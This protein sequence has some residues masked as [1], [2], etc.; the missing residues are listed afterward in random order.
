[1]KRYLRRLTAGCLAVLM[2][3][4]NGFAVNTEGNEA[5]ANPL[6]GGLLA[7]PVPLLPDDV[8]L[9]GLQSADD[10]VDYSEPYYQEQLEQRFK[11]EEAL[12]ELQELLDRINNGEE[13]GC[14]ISL[15]APAEEKPEEEPPAED[16]PVDEKPVEEPSEENKPDATPSE[17]TD[18]DETE[19]PT[20][21]TTDDVY[22][23]EPDAAAE[24][25]PMM[26]AL[27]RAA[28]PAQDATT[29][30]YV[31]ANGVPITIEDNGSGTKVTWDGGGTGKEITVS[32][33]TFVFGGSKDGNVTSTDITFKSGKVGYIVG[34]GLNG[35]VTGDT[36]VTINNNTI[37]DSVKGVYGGGVF[38]A[39]DGTANVTVAGINATTASIYGGGMNSG[40]TVGSTSVTISGG[41]LGTVYAG[42][43]KGTVTGNTALLINGGTISWAYG[44][45]SNGSVDGAATV[46]FVGGTV[47]NNL[48][49]GGNKGTVSSTKVTV[50]GGTVSGPSETNLGGVVA[51]GAQASVTNSELTIRSDLKFACGGGHKTGAASTNMKVN[52]ERGEVTTLVGG[53]HTGVENNEKIEVNVS[54]ASLGKIG[55][56]NQLVCAD[57]A[58][59]GSAT[60]TFNMTGGRVDELR[61]GF[62]GSSG[63][64]T[65]KVTGGNIMK[66]GIGVPLKDGSG[67]T[68]YPVSMAKVESGSLVRDLSGTGDKDKDILVTIN[69]STWYSKLNTSGQLELQ[70]PE[71]SFNAEAI[72]VVVSGSSEYKSKESS[73]LPNK[74]NSIE[75][76]DKGGPYFIVNFGAEDDNTGSVSCDGK[77]QYKDELVSS[78]SLTFN[79]NPASGYKLVGWWKNGVKDT[80]AT[81]NTLTLNITESVEI[82]ARFVVASSITFGSLPRGIRNVS[83]TYAGLGTPVE[84]NTDTGTL[85]GVQKDTAVTFSTASGSDNYEFVSWKVNDERVG[86]NET[87]FKWTADGTSAKVEA[88]YV[89]KI[90]LRNLIAKAKPIY[91]DTSEAANKNYYTSS[92][93]QDADFRKAY[94]AA[95]AA[96]GKTEL[97]GANAIPTQTEID[98][99]KT[100]LESTMN[101]VQ[102]R[103]AIPSLTG[104]TI[105]VSKGGTVVSNPAY[106]T[107]GGAVT[108]TVTPDPGYELKEADGKKL[109][110]TYTERSYDKATGE[111]KSETKEITPTK[112]ETN[113]PYTYTFNMPDWGAVVN[114][115]AEFTTP[116][117]DV[118]Y[119]LATGNDG[120]GTIVVASKPDSI[121]DSTPTGGTLSNVTVNDTIKFKATAE[122][123]K[124]DGKSYSVGEWTVTPADGAVI[125]S[126]ETKDTKGTTESICTLTKVTK[127][128]TVTV[129]FT[130][131]KHRITFASGANGVAS[132]DAAAGGVEKD[133]SDNNFFV[134]LAGE[135]VTIKATPTTG[136]VPEATFTK[137]DGSQSQ[138]K[139]V[140]VNEP[141]ENSTEYTLTFKMPDEPTTVNVTFKEKPLTVNCVVNG[142]TAHGTLTA[143]KENGEAY[144]KNE[145]SQKYE[146][147]FGEKVYINVDP[148]TGYRIKDTTLKCTEE[149]TTGTPRTVTLK[150]EGNGLYSF[151]MP[152]YP[153]KVEV[154]YEPE[155]YTITKA[156]PG[157]DNSTTAGKITLAVA[158]GSADPDD[159]L[160]DGK[161]YY[162]NEVTVAA[163]PLTLAGADPDASN[164]ADYEL[165]K[166]TYKPTNEADGKT[167]TTI[168]KDGSGNY[169]FEM[170]AYPVTVTAYFIRLYKITDKTPAPATGENAIT[171][172]A[173]V[174][175]NP[176]TFTNKVAKAKHQDLVIITAEQDGST[177]S[178]LIV[179]RTGTGLTDNLTPNETTG[180]FELEM[181]GTEDVEITVVFTP[182]KFNITVDDT[183]ANGTV[184]V[185]PNGL[186][187]KDADKTIK[188]TSKPNT[189]YEL[190][191]LQVI[192]TGTAGKPAT[193]EDVVIPE[194]PTTAESTGTVTGKKLTK[195]TGDGSK[196]ADGNELYTFKINSMPSNGLTV[197]PVF[198]RKVYKVKASTYAVGADGK[199]AENS[200][201]GT[202]TA[203]A[204]V[205]AAEAG[206]TDVPTNVP[207]GAA[208][209]DSYYQNLVTVT[210]TAGETKQL[211]AL[212]YTYDGLENPIK[213]DLTGNVAGS[214]PVAKVKQS[215]WDSTAS[216]WV[217]KYVY[218][219]KMPAS[220]VTFKAT[221][222]DRVYTVTPEITY[223]ESDGST[224][225]TKP[226]TE[227]LTVNPLTFKH[228]DASKEAIQIRLNA[229]DFEFNGAPT[230]AVT[231]VAS[232]AD[233]TVTP[234]GDTIYKIIPTNITEANITIKIKLKKI[235]TQTDDNDDNIPDPVDPGETPIA[236]SGGSGPA[237]ESLDPTP[238]A[239]KTE[240]NTEQNTPVTT[241]TTSSIS[242]AID[243]AASNN[244]EIVIKAEAVTPPAGA[245]SNPTSDP[246]A[247]P[248]SDPT[249]NPTPETVNSKAV[250]SIPK[251][252]VKAIADAAK[253]TDP[254]SKKVDSLKLE[255]QSGATAVFNS[256]A[257]AKIAEAYNTEGATDKN[258]EIVI[259]PATDMQKTSFGAV[260]QNIVDDSPLVPD[261]VYSFEVKIDGQTV[262][263]SESGGFGEG[264][265][266]TLSIPYTL[267]EGEDPAKVKACYIDTNSENMFQEIADSYYSDGKVIFTTTHFSLY[268]V[269][270]HENP[271][272][273]IE[274]HWA[275]EAIAAMEL[276]GLVNGVTKTEFMPDTMLKRC[277][278]VTMLGRLAKAET[279]NVTDA[280]FADV[281]MDS[282]YA[283][284]MAWAK[285]NGLAQGT[286]NGMFS[287]EV[288]ITREQLAVLLYRFADIQ[289]DNVP[290]ASSEELFN[291]DDSI[292]SWAKEAVYALRDS[293]I[294]NGMG[295]NNYNP[296]DNATRAQVCTV[297]QRML[298]KFDKD[299]IA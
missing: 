257:I 241:V 271:F 28:T 176:I 52:L 8:S 152:E 23:V 121:T 286:G 1:M 80:T 252:A 47:V 123:N 245:A 116:K 96:V 177:A 155:P 117:H 22:V 239:S 72:R 280:A 154:E 91:T 98:T 87:S 192:R 31:F 170:P 209:G 235:K 269:M 243:K 16:V 189:G 113:Y 199:P 125:T 38:G 202:V 263:S 296:R 288:P 131:N 135:T 69:G 120:K 201:A 51:G 275:E 108:L 148:D 149:V 30:S 93:Q 207:T 218:A 298:H 184:E 141:A 188:V 136:Y 110:L 272:T 258:V 19:A 114:V 208:S 212:E 156:T 226:A 48:Y 61:K 179:K 204:T 240:Y 147:N 264:G 167:E 100:T 75:L 191:K 65:S 101:L 279:E 256:E 4:V 122:R 163:A 139:P 153:V 46:D 174:S 11:E 285:G 17:E 299:T 83:A 66:N 225:T 3:P 97:T 254:E 160:T 92:S 58:K 217:D 64:L 214:S 183:G 145:T 32:D 107:K 18:T 190:E 197:T 255:T 172:S 2:L 198:K 71:D 15:D 276:K 41:T 222:E 89:N 234:D 282:Y 88:E 44:G 132:I 195:L 95:V 223:Y 193:A 111:D 81:G 236:S 85:S 77:T 169:K 196:D 74:V 99:L 90:D 54:G 248:A 102:S 206:E 220:D 7:E 79:A 242:N 283:P 265:K 161:A 5:E 213:V 224:V 162:K 232:G 12:Y 105:T 29:A 150:S 157:T 228:G 126:T 185:S 284:Y 60:V 293:E 273:D 55:V 84:S 25:S 73:V 27:F 262:G 43:Q 109:K 186:N 36:H 142:T 253:S 86:G 127:P 115:V 13:T 215:A 138:E 33:S 200:T 210:V 175:N 291:D 266:V 62:Y 261:T 94:E 21:E 187:Y 233:V 9:V 10:G 278:L 57:N 158:K 146:V 237:T 230:A 50:D 231:G 103:I 130:Q 251:E 270:Y 124:A 104:G 119:A 246:A 137:T 205:K 129:S 165:E 168:T 166:I 292:S 249:T 290:E 219:F 211:K 39:V 173:E 194:D 140:N 24:E 45:G 216:K 59:N 144:T 295:D 281:P 67:K 274:G 171:V 221:F 159:V 277:M 238:A 178:K 63:S 14:S 68:L 35:N 289:Y 182:D 53:N 229:G 268:G 106:Q 151:T 42:G 128:V 70:L 133:S 37:A 6:P 78:G 260:D 297:I 143:Q 49:G 40:S 118:T 76:E 227:Y 247:D 250:F 26:A 112:N 287:P 259:K 267:A 180:E 203:V 134:G 294:I 56:A 20:E 244:G 34:G 82:R 181:T 164:T